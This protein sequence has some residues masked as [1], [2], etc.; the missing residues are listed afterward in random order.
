[1][2]EAHSNERELFVHES[3]LTEGES[4]QN[5]DIFVVDTG[6]LVG[7][8]FRLAASVSDSATTVSWQTYQLS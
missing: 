8:E 1:M 5:F 6:C 3:E 4:F 7:P 2:E